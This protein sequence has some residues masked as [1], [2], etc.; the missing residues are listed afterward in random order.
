MGASGAWSPVYI[1]EQTRQED[2]DQYPETGRGLPFMSG[3]SLIE[4]CLLP[5]ISS[6]Y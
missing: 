4:A 5:E 6:P 2:P 3:S 1:A